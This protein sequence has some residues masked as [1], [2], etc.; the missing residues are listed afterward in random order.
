MKTFSGKLAVVASGV[1][2]CL[3]ATWAAWH[4]LQP[5]PV[6]RDARPVMSYDAAAVFGADA[7]AYPRTPERTA[8]GRASPVYWQNR[9]DYQLSARLDEVHGSLTGHAVIRY[10]NNSPNPLAYLWLQ[11][12][13]NIYRADSIGS[14]SAD[15]PRDTPL[16]ITQ[17]MQVTG[18]HLDTGH[19]LVA[20]PHSVNDT[21]MRVDLPV[22]LAAHGGKLQLV[23][24][25]TFAFG[26]AGLWAR[27]G[28]SPA[29]ARYSVAQWYPRM[30]VYDDLRGWETLP[31]RGVG[32][33]YLEYGDIRYDLDVPWDYLVGG[34]GELL[35]PA[36]VLTAVERQRLNQALADQ[37]KVTIAP[38]AEMGT[39]ARRPVQQGRLVWRFEIKNAR[40][41]VWGASPDYVWDAAGMQ[42]PGGKRALAMAFYPPSSNGWDSTAQ[43]IKNIL[44]YYSTSFTPYPY[45]TATVIAGG[46]IGMEYPACVFLNEKWSGDGFLNALM[47]HEFA[48]S[49]FPIMVGSDER[50]Y[51]WMDEGIVTFMVRRAAAAFHGHADTDLSYNTDK[52]VSLMRAF[53]RPIM[54]KSDDLPADENRGL[55]YDKT[56]YALLLLR[57][58]VLGPKIFDRILNDYI[59]SW[60]YKHPTPYDFFRFFDNES[61]QDLSWFWQEWFFENW[62]LDQAVTGIAYRDH[63]P[64]KG[65]DIS[66]QNEAGMAM[67]AEIR[68]ETCDGKS[69]DLRLP[70]EIWSRGPKWSFHVDTGTAIKSATIDPDRILPDDNRD[71]NSLT[72]ACK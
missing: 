58:Q 49:W 39:P 70:V 22:P 8:D 71:N 65:A 41:V 20:L 31:F 62:R 64:S 4:R 48:H 57:E 37:K 67:P 32:E 10:T 5:A 35:N 50:R 29:K 12:E 27:N 9:A 44:T 61:G 72:Q 26:E 33:F 34:S 51:T 25:Y 56:A 38:P 2:L 52:M 17:G 68:I 60:A 69:Q 43:N 11:L 19:G 59:R 45:G 13:Q 66:L 3:V 40:D 23:V 47:M 14:L 24:D 36:E 63:D 46:T 42:L 21:E 18:V 53:T 15:N 7:L 30:A 28:G 55:E 1:A 16:R 6:H 54:T